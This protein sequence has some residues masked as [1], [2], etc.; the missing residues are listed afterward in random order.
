MAEPQMTHAAEHI[1]SEGAEIPTPI[2]NEAEKVRGATWEKVL[3][4]IGPHECFI[5]DAASSIL[6]VT[7]DFTSHTSQFYLSPEFA[8]WRSNLLNMLPQY[9]AL[10]DRSTT[11]IMKIMFPHYRSQSISMQRTQREVLKRIAKILGED[12]F[13][14]VKKLDVVLKAPEMHWNQVQGLAPFYGLR[15]KGWRVFLKTGDSA[16]NLVK[17]GDEWDMKLRKTLR[18]MTEMIEF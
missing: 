11:I 6:T 1:I 14:N 18:E 13:E 15:V 2:V 17:A 9:S 8:T 10:T 7:I 4:S 12:G 5:Y 16:A 3:A